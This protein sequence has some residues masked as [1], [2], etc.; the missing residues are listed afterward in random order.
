MLY[1]SLK[2]RK[3]TQSKNAKFAKTKRKNN[4]SGKCAVC[5][6]KRSR[7]IKEP[8]NSGLLGSLGLKT[9]LSSSLVLDV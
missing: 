5:D 8:E 2:S 1:Y 3:Y 7:F 6:S 9:L 4:V